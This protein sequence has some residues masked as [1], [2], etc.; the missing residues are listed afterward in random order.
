[1]YVSECV[2]HTLTC[3]VVRRVVEPFV[4]GP[5]IAVYSNVTEQLVTKSGVA[6]TASGSANMYHRKRGHYVTG[7]TCQEAIESKWSTFRNGGIKYR[8]V[9]FIRI[10]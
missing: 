7:R 5:G 4:K 10:K 9:S 2:R 8:Y 6:F 3:I 1:M